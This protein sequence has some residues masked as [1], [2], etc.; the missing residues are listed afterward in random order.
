MKRIYSLDLMKLYLAY[1]VAMFHVGIDWMPGSTVAVQI[2]FVIS[3]YFLGKK[4]YATRGKDYDQWKYTLDHVKSLYPHYLFS[5]AMIF[6]YL[7]ARALVYLLREPSAAAVEEILLSVY[8]QIPDLLLLQ[9]SYHYHNSMNYPLWQISAL[10]ISGYFVFGLLNHNEKVS[11]TLVFPAAIL[12]IESLM[13]G[14][15]DLWINYGPF[16]LPLLRAFGPMCLGV[17]VYW[18]STTEH[19][20]KLLRFRKTWNV[21]SIL[22]LASIV[23]F[24]NHDQIFLITTSVV[25]LACTQE[26]SWINRL[27][28]HAVFRWC[29]NFSYAV[30]LNHA[31]IQ[32]FSYARIFPKLD[33]FGIALTEGQQ[34]MVYFVILSVYSVVTLQLVSW[35][36]KYFHR[37]QTAVKAD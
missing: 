34:G 14:Q 26:N 6:L 13:R 5:L 17:L 24:G 25:I 4:F 32:R 2:F 8:D 20:G 7:T 15:T 11:R 29:G 3:G 28:N 30:Y 37:K 12:M 31:L 19:F 16:F 33:A 18:F 36:R 10:L 35:L 22:A 9:S 27:L 23:A 21:A 1:V